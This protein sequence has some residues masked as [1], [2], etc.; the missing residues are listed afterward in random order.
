MRDQYPHKGPYQ[1]MS[2]TGLPGLLVIVVL[3]VGVW[4]LFPKVFLPVLAVVIGVSLVLALALRGWRA[5]HPSDK[6]MLHLNSEPTN[7]K[8][9][10]V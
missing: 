1:D 6:S 2:P 4:S 8:R 9:M 3:V 10:D 5:H 7:K